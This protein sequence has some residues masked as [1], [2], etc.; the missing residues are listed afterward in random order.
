MTGERGGLG[1]HALHHAAVAAQ[2]VDAV[3][4][5]RVARAVEVLGEPARRDRHADAGGDA[6]SQRPGRGLD[7]RGP[8]VF[9]MAGAFAV[10]LAE[11]LQVVERHRRGAEPLVIGVD[12]L[13][14]GQ[15]QHRIEQGRGMARGQHKA[16]AVGPDRIVGIEAE[17]FLPQRVHHRRHRHRRAGM[18]GIGRLHRVDAQGADGIDRDVFDGAGRRSHVRSLHSS[19][20]HR[21]APPRPNR[22][23]GR[24]A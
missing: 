9:R 18:A 16:V 13:D 3:V 12:R 1:G 4:E 11:A 19:R 21:P 7:P 17:E 23:A 8:V 14:P 22:K 5:Q 20:R 24:A 15:V 10:E 2:R 6:L